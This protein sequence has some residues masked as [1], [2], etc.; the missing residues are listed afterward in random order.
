MIIVVPFAGPVS[1]AVAGVMIESCR[2]TM[3][4]VPIWQL[5]DEDTPKLDGVAGTIRRKWTGELATFH[6]EHMSNL[7]EDEILRLDYDLIV[8]RDVTPVF[9]FKFDLALTRRPLNDPTCGNLMRVKNPHNHG[10]IFLRPKA[11]LFF[12]RALEEYS[13]IENKDRW[14]DIAYALEN[15]AAS[16]VCRWIE[17]P[18]ERYNYTP[19]KRDEDVSF[20]DIIHYKGDRKHWMI[21]NDQARRD[22]EAVLRMVENR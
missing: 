14:M 22:G 10:V 17:L 16:D 20:A 6:L 21:D 18:G 12:E 5:T 8:K 3:P 15:A 11:K 1:T 13:S 19:K 7:P 9:G 2:K 4:H